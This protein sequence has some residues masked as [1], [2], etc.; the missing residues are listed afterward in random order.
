MLCYLKAPASKQL[1]V[2]RIFFW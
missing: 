2:Y 1:T